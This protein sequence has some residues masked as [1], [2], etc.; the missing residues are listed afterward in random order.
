MNL[1]SVPLPWIDL[2]KRAFDIP[3]FRKENRVTEDQAIVGETR[4]CGNYAFIPMEQPWC[5]IVGLGSSKL[6][7][8]CLWCS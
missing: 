7:M 8:L 2:L 6:F 3:G 4:Q 1:N 5:S